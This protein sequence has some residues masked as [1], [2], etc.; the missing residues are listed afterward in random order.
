MG[1]S[2]EHSLGRILVVDDDLSVVELLTEMLRQEDVDARGTTSALEV[3]GLI[4]DFQPHALFIDLEMP[5]LNGLDLLKSIRDEHPE[6]P[7]VIVSGFVDKAALLRAT[8]LGIS[9]VIEKPFGSAALRQH[10]R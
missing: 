7:V 4:D 3:L 6:L 8:R 9:A 5:S 10:L 2:R 1:F